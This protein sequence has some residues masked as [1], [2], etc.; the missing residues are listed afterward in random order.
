MVQKKKKREKDKKEMF[1]ILNKNF[2]KK[3]YIFCYPKILFENV[4]FFILFCNVS[5]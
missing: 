4:I 1:V 3:N 2:V 5:Y